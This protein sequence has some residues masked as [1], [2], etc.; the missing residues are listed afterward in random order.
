MALELNSWCKFESKTS[1]VF[2]DENI[3][4]WMGWV[5]FTNK[6]GEL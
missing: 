6:N 1:D 2:I 3:A 4:I 5:T